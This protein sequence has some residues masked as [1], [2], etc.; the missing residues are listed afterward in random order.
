MLVSPHKK[1]GH[2]HDLMIALRSFENVADLR[3]LGITVTNQ[4]LIRGK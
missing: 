2:I 1:S 3:Y 4:N